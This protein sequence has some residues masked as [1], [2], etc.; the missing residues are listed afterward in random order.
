MFEPN[1]RS[2]VILELLSRL[3]LPTP[4]VKEAV[5]VAVGHGLVAGRS[6]SG[7]C[8]A[9]GLGAAG[10]AGGA[11]AHIG[12][13]MAFPGAPSANLPCLTDQRFLI[14]D[15][16]AMV[17]RR[18]IWVCPAGQQVPPWEQRR[19]SAPVVA[20]PAPLAPAP[21]AISRA[22][23]AG[24]GARRWRGPL[25]HLRPPA[26]SGSRRH[27]P[28]PVRRSRQPLG[29]AQRGATAIAPGRRSPPTD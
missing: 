5:P 24:R 4:R 18:G 12:G 15:G 27:W 1:A 29:S 2:T 11:A 28:A 8:A 22:R 26:P 16:E 25:A 17:A 21:T 3:H 6:S 10:G 7:V 14:W 23:Q 20:W 9:P 13:A 19:A